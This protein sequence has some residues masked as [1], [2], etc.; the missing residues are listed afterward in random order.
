MP[1]IDDPRLLQPRCDTLQPV[2]N[3]HHNPWFE[4]ICRGGYFTT[5]CPQAQA[6]VL[7]V[8][9]GDSVVM[10]KVKRPILADE[11]WELPAGGLDL[12]CESAAEGAARELHEETGIVVTDISRLV[13]L[14]PLATDPN[15]NPRLTFVFRVALSVDEFEVRGSHD[16]EVREVRRI[17]LAEARAM[18]L[19]GRIYVT[20]PVALIGRLLME[21]EPR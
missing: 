16:A 14:P 6:V 3:V 11:T 20:M 9:G 15:R 10:V 1:T 2:E 19:D 4:V 5:E 17:S 8:V 13:P 21:R 7:P 18:V 12:E